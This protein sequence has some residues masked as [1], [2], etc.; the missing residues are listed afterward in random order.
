M[1]PFGKVTTPPWLAAFGGG[2]VSGIAILINIVL[3]TLIV[4]AGIYVVLNLILAGYGFISAGGDPK[5]IQ[6]ATAKIWQSLLGLVVAA[7]AFLIAAIIGEILYGDLEH[8]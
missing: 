8:Y 2:S 6:D 1:N 4:F 7:G 3:R 5:R